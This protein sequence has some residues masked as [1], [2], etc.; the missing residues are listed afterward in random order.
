[1]GP[2][3]LGLMH[4]DASIAPIGIPHGCPNP[5]PRLQFRGYVEGFVPVASAHTGRHR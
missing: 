4:A 3:L 5:L 2:M 1:M